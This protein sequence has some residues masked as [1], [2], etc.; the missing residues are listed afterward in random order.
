M[1]RSG[2]AGLTVAA[3]LC[4][5]AN[6]LLARGAL[7]D[8][9]ADPATFTSVRLGA[10]SVALALAAL[11][12]RRWRSRAGSWA[13]AL[14]LFGY[15]AAFSLSYVRI[16]AGIGALLLFPSVQA[17]MI[18]WSVARGTRPNRQQW[19]GI[20]LTVAGLAV[21]TLPGANAPDAIGALLM[22]LAGVSWGVYS[23][24]GRV[25]SDPIATTTD[26]F[27]RTVPMAL[28]L[29]LAYG[30]SSPLRATGE[31]L[32]LAVVSGAIASAGGYIMWYAILPVLGPTRA[33]TVQVA[34]PGLA[35]AGAVVLLGEALT[36]RL[37]VSAAA[38]LAGIALT[39]A[40]GPRPPSGPAAP[41]R[42]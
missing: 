19:L 24:R 25:A 42:P 35:A 20:S 3:L 6:S 4:F 39:V 28:V 27:V 2:V 26:N 36:A 33:A 14:A 30:G 32:A 15:A 1:R 37:A 10:G 34:A 16:D 40:A 41:T 9:L 22:I 17:T 12:T 18:G 13:S 8:G 5:A 31:G 23:I 29:M 7:R 11:A 21:L 38:I